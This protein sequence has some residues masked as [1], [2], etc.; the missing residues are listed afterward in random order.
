[1]LPGSVHVADGVAPLIQNTSRPGPWQ[2]LQETHL[3][4]DPHPFLG[5]VP[6]NCFDGVNVQLKHVPARVL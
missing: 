4:A 6:K 3:V 5:H 1:M 2:K